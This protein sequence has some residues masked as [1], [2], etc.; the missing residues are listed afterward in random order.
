[1]LQVPWKMWT[2]SATLA[3]TYRIATGMLD[4]DSTT[5]WYGSPRT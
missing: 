3:T 4:S 2:A 1:M 5:L